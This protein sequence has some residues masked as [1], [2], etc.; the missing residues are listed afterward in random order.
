MKMK[1]TARSVYGELP[2][3]LFEMRQIIRQK[4]PGS[5]QND[6]NEW[7]RLQT[8]HYI[9]T[10]DKPTMNEVAEYLRIKAPSAT[11]L[12]AHLDSHGFIERLP[13]NDRRVTRLSLTEAGAKILKGYGAHSEK[14][15]RSAFS[16]LEEKEVCTLRDILRKM[17]GTQKKK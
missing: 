15:M 11:S 7:M 17:I 14:M 4:L 2:S 6:P 16:K 8:M 10:H 5:N 9:A 1:S 3:L 13:G 12:I